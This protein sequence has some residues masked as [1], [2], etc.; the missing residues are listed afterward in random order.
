MFHLGIFPRQDH[1]MAVLFLH[2]DGWWL[3]ELQ[4][5]VTSVVA[6]RHLQLRP[7]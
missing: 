7:C 5:Y 1:T 2:P 3:G 6:P 4:D